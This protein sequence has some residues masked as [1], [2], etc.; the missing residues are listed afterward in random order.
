MLARLLL[1]Y[2][3]FILYGFYYDLLYYFILLFIIILQLFIIF[4]ITVISGSIDI[5]FFIIVDYSY[6]LF[7][8]NTQSFF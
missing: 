4:N 5:F 7:I 3:I 8:L 6:Y 1:C 2:I